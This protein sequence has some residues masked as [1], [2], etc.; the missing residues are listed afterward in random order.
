MNTFMAAVTVSQQG[1]SVTA[2]SMAGLLAEGLKRCGS[3]SVAED[4]RGLVLNVVVRSKDLSALVAEVEAEDVFDREVSESKVRIA[5]M[6][7]FVAFDPST[8]VGRMRWRQ[9]AV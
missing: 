2:H 3:E 8:S 1:G 6:P 5:D 7:C 9:R 4:A